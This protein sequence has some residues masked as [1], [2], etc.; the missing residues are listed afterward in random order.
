MSLTPCWWGGAEK[1]LKQARGCAQVGR[2][3]GHL[4]PPAKGNNLLDRQA[5][6]DTSHPIQ[7]RRMEQTRSEDRDQKG[8][9]APAQPELLL[10]RGLGGRLGR[11]SSGSCHIA[12]ASGQL[13]VVSMQRQEASRHTENE[14]LV[15]SIG[16][17][18]LPAGTG[19]KH[20]LQRWERIRLAKRWG[21]TA[22][23]SLGL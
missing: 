17:A 2:Q 20:A 6:L 10:E 4:L 14:I 8:E 19:Q 13:W 5:T 7:C 18:L 21:R 11:K 16:K 9:W 22:C 23:P 1:P 3:D 12:A 15:L